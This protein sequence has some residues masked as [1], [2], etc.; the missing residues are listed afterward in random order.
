MVL[1]FYH[2]RNLRLKRKF[3][4]LFDRFVDDKRASLEDFILTFYQDMILLLIMKSMTEVTVM[5]WVEN[6]LRRNRCDVTY[7]VVTKIEKGRMMIHN[8]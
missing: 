2:F 4:S 6:R 5:D 8:A 1:C 7:G 3:D